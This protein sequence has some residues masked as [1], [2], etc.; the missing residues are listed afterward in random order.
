[1][2][3]IIYNKLVRDKIP[4]IIEQTGKSCTYSILSEEEYLNM[5][6]AKLNEELA[7]Y[8]EDKSMEELADLLEVMKAVALARGSSLE[9]VEE[10][11][12]AKANKR[13]GFEKKILLEEVIES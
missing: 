10:I 2:K 13:G 5:L 3:K 12:R 11:R 1:M 7:E 8:Q 4:E 6:D 9:E